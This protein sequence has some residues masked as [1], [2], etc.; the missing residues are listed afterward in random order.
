MTAFISS[1]TKGGVSVALLTVPFLALNAGA[2]PGA[3]APQL[4]LHHQSVGRESQQNRRIITGAGCA[5]GCD[6]SNDTRD[7]STV[8]R[9]FESCGAEK[10]EMRRF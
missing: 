10:S 3:S 1:W 5:C 4:Q 8:N 2:S 6:S 7:L 9:H